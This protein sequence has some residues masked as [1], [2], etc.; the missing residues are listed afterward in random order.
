MHRV[1]IT[2]LGAVTPLGNNVTDFWK[3]LIDGK[4]GAVPITKFDPKNF[5]TKFACEVKNFDPLNFLEK[6]EARKID[7]FTQ[8]AIAATDE[9]VKDSQITK[10]NCDYNRVGVIWGTGVGGIQTI[11]EEMISFARNAEIPRFSPFFITK[12]IANIASGVITIR[13]GF[14]GVSFATV[15]ACTS[16]NN[17]IAD[18]LYLIK[19]G[20]AKIIIAGGSEAPITKASIGGFN[21]SKALSVRNDSPESASRPFDLTRD[22]F[23]MGEGAGAIVVEEMEHA[24]KRGANIYCELISCGFASDAYHITA[25]HPDGEGAILAIEDALSEATITPGDVDYINAHATST[26]IGDISECK[27]ISK[28]FANSLDSLNVSATKS[29]TG[30][31]LGGAGAVEAIACILAIKNNIVPPTINLTEIDPISKKN[32]I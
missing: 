3:N 12:M 1:V 25:S 4:S 29:M 30:H 2:G 6:S 23:V 17:A 24:I 14:R 26:P 16:S 20:K 31:L 13:H 9:C 28:V 11:E 7:L 27:A 19:C 22:G 10:D 21:A 15:S 8:Y 32:L 18:A 5:K